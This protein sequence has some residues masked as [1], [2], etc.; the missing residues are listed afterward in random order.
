LEHVKATIAKCPLILTCD[1]FPFYLW[2]FSFYLY[3]L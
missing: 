3:A 2:W 1:D